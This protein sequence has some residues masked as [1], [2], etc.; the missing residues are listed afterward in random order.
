MKKLT[1]SVG[2]LIGILSASAQDTTLRIFKEKKYIYLTTTQVK[3]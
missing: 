1:L 2:L 3:F